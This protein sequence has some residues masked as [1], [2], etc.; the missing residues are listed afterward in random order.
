MTSI[1]TNG[2]YPKKKFNVT[3]KLNVSRSKINRS[4]PFLSSTLYKHLATALLR[5]AKSRHPRYCH[6]EANK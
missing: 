5:F 4:H 6:L 2:T 1:T 3:K